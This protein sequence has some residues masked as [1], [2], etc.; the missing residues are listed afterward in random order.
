MTSFWIISFWN[1]SMWSFLNIFWYTCKSYT[2]IEL[3]K[4][5]DSWMNVFEKKEDDGGRR[6][7]MFLLWVKAQVIWRVVRRFDLDREQ[8][9]CT[10]VWSGPECGT[11]WSSSVTGW[12]AVGSVGSV[13]WFGGAASRDFTGKGDTGWLASL[14]QNPP[15][16]TFCRLCILW[17]STKLPPTPKNC[18]LVSFHSVF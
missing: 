5:T 18:L 14:T 10:T 11:L 2:S 1:I 15:P 13:V 9:C 7:T 17:Y 8:C 12:A 16:S 3:S 4:K 6:L